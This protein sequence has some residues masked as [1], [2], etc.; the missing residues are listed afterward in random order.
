[1]HDEAGDRP[2]PKEPVGRNRFIAPLGQADPLG[3]LATPMAQ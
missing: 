3:A 2:A 1:M